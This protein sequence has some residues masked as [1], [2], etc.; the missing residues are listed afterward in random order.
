MSDGTPDVTVAELALAKSITLEVLVMMAVLPWVQNRAREGGVEALREDLQL[1]ARAIGEQAG[2][3]SE[4]V[5][6][7]TRI[8][9]DQM[10][11]RIEHVGQQVVAV[12]EREASASGSQ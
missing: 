8:Y 12:H 7:A 4:G 1:A 11:R 6:T 2:G 10:L 9:A 5:S 3:Y